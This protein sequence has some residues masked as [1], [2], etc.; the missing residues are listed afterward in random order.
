M[1]GPVLTLTRTLLEGTFES[2]MSCSSMA[3]MRRA[4]I[5]LYFWI[6]ASAFAAAPALIPLPQVLIQTNSGSFT[7]CPP[8]IIP[9][10]PAPAPTPILIG[11][12]GRETAEYL[13]TTLFQSTGYRFQIFTN[14]GFEAVP[15]A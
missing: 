12:A 15:Q 11:R 8:Q 7:L 3:M 1:S 6:A 4:V 10:A 14:S 5:A 2:Y 13:A 9:G